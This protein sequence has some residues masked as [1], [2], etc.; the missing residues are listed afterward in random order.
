M[1]SV[2]TIACSLLAALSSV[3]AAGAERHVVLV[4]WDGMRPDFVSATN[5][6]TLFELKRNGVF[7]AHNHAVYVTSTEVNGTAL[8]TGFYPEHSG[9]I[10][11]REYRAELDRLAAIDTESLQAMRDAESNGVP[12]LDVSTMEQ[13]LQKQKHH[14]AVAGTKPVVLLHDHAERAN[15]DINVVVDEGKSLP[16]GLAANLVE[17]LGPF[18]DQGD[19]KTNRDLWT[20]RALTEQLWKNGVP[21]FSLLWLAEPDNTQHATGVGSPEALAA[22]HNSDGALSLVMAGLKAKGVYDSTDI[23]VVSDHGF[24]TIS[25]SVNISKELQRGGFKTFRKFEKPPEKGDVLVVGLGGSV[26][27]YVIGRDEETIGKLV[28]FLQTQEGVGPIFTAHARDGTFSL[29]DAM[30]H[31]RHA[32]D[33]VFSMQWTGATNSNGHLGMVVTESQGSN[34]GAPTQRATHA[35]L[36]PFDLHNTLVAA[37]P[38]LRRGFV[39]ELPTGNLD[40]APTILN[41]LGV[42]PERPMDGRVLFEALNVSDAKSPRIEPKE[43]QA[44]A[45]LPS[46]EWTQRLKTSRVNGVIYLEEGT[47][48]FR[49]RSNVSH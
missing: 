32:P 37:G 3:L 42:N 5:T 33:I 47:A 39:D 44:H 9:V 24:S 18:A 38:D 45:S 30:I 17:A 6:P 29:D 36:S 13:T 8:A 4:V 27:L 25:A 15:D 49:G 28:R 34:L 16:E 1:R 10:G 40:V 46:G 43:L 11:N 2:L 48:E 14:T 12:Y 26:L 23:F 41:I 31:S 20:A 19:T 35:S 7:F 21:S 22:I